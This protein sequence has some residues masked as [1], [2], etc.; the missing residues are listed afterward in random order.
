VRLVQGSCG[1]CLLLPCPFWPQHSACW[2]A[3]GEL[4][5]SVAGQREREIEIERERPLPEELS[6][7]L[8]TGR[9]YFKVSSFSQK[10]CSPAKEA[11]KDERA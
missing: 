5:L 1:D 9:R 4:W 8:A 10:S 3:K 6:H 11:P 2:K 7:F